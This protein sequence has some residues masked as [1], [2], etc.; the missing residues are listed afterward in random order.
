MINEHLV[1]GPNAYAPFTPKSIQPLA[2]RRLTNHWPRYF[3]KY[4]G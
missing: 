2:C 3:T 4:T 1:I